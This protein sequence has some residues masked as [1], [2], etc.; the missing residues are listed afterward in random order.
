[1][2]DMFKEFADRKIVKLAKRT[3]KTGVAI[4]SVAAV[5]GVAHIGFIASQN[6]EFQNDNKSEEGLGGSSGD[7]GFSREDDWIPKGLRCVAINSSTAPNF[8]SKLPEIRNAF[9][10]REA[11]GKIGGGVVERSGHAH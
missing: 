10:A 9:R 6:Q 8:D 11:L 2:P 1:M 5:V 4:A 3:A 7:L